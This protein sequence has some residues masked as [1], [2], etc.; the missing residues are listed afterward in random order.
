MGTRPFPARCAPLRHKHR[1]GCS[2][3][4]SRMVRAHDRGEEPFQNG[5]DRV[6][7]LSPWPSFERCSAWHLFCV[8]PI[9]LPWWTAPPMSPSPPNLSAHLLAMCPVFPQN[10]PSSFHCYF[11]CL[12]FPDTFFCNRIFTSPNYRGLPPTQFP[13]LSLSASHQQW[14]YPL[15]PLEDSYFMGS[16]RRWVEK[17]SPEKGNCHL[18]VSKGIAYSVEGRGLSFP[19]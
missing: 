13:V 5:S 18:W 4:H 2:L 7:S 19:S 11:A 10:F 16:F 15:S 9:V 17:R 8:F 3:R 14:S 6:W 1:G 12:L